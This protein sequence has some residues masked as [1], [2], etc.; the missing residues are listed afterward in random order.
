MAFT[1]SVLL[2]PG[3]KYDTLTTSDS[4]FFFGVARE[5]NESNGMVEEYSLS[6]APYGWP[7]G[8][9]DQGQ[10]LLTVMLYRAVSAFN[11]NIGLMD[12]ARY[13]APLLFALS[14][15]PI[16]LIG[17]ELGGDFAGCSAAFFGAVLTSS[18]YWNKVGA[19][20]REPIILVLT[21][22]TIY[23]TIR[24]FKAPRS[25]VPQ[26]ALLAGLAYGIFGMSWGGSSY[27][28]PILI[29]GMIFVL[30]VGYIEKLVRK[31]ADLAKADLPVIRE[32]LH[33][34]AGGLGTLVV[35]TFVIWALGG[36]S[37]MF[38]MGFAQTLLGYAGMNVAWIIL[39]VLAGWVIY[40][41]MGMFGT[42][43]NLITKSAFL[44]RSVYWIILIFGIIFVYQST[45][46]GEGVS[47]ARYAG[48][49]AAPG[50]WNEIVYRLYGSGNAAILTTFVF[51]LIALAFIKFCWSRKRWELLVFP[52]LLVIAA[53]VWP[54]MGQIRFERQWWPFVPALAGVG[55][56]VL[57]SL[58][59]RLSFESFGEWLRHFRRPVV[60]A[61]SISIITAP[62]IFNAYAVAG[63]TTPPTEWH[64]AGMNEGLM[65]A[66]TWLREST[67]KNSVVA[68]EWSFGHVLTGTA[69]RATVAD[70][71]EGAGELGKWENTA[72]V[73]PPDYVYWVEGGSAKFPGSGL[74][75][76]YRANAVNGRRPDVDRLTVTG[77]ENEFA[78]LLRWY[79]DD[80]GV[81]INYV[82]FLRDATYG[83][84]VFNGTLAASSNIKE[85][86]REVSV[87][88]ENWMIFTFDN[89]E[90]IFD[91]VRF[92][93]YVEEGGE[94]EYLAG[95]M[96]YFPETGS[97]R[98]PS[99][100]SEPDVSEFLWVFLSSEGGVLGG[101]LGEF[102]GAPM[103]YR[104][105]NNFEVPNY[106]SVAYTSSNGLV[107]VVEIDHENLP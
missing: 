48:E 19:F 68:I 10:P 71:V 34:I 98:G 100:Y 15:I 82:M 92:I 9:S 12:V 29:G 50:S 26:F 89:Q 84:K 5:I 101:L 1:T 78:N 45:A 72:T 8:I 33:L 13:W 88:N 86:N 66:F 80:Y 77:D 85:N 83:V 46:A 37:P 104:I 30:L 105:F 38:L 43:R 63:Q 75:P 35:M 91:P 55:A 41:T 65:D 67:P 27:I 17:K 23:L 60:V 59:R 21:A 107:K 76:L 14:L 42:P 99:F 7:V 18:I 56:A 32:N 22:W 3:E 4:G 16:F 61:F 62:F 57:V 58:V 20:D 31:S 90:V 87:R 11:P 47:F 51:A 40:L 81:K 36:Q 2:I 93:A 70:G 28:M 53:L 103:L 6:H 69:E 24:V 74:D 96:Y 106:V 102:V 94:N 97:Y 54:G 79:R 95:V 39:F 49:M 44:I 25:S 73:R 52:W 64:G